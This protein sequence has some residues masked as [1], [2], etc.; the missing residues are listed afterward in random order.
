MRLSRAF[1]TALLEPRKGG[2]SSNNEEPSYP[3]LPGDL[4]VEKNH[5]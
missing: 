5:R 3:L 1:R 2:G 4:L